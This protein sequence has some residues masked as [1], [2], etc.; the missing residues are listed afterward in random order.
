MCGCVDEDRGERESVCV[1]EGVC[2]RVSMRRAQRRGVSMRRERV[3][4]SMRRGRRESE[5]GHV[6]ER[7][8]GRGC[9][10]E[11]VCVDERVCV[12]MREREGEGGCVDERAGCVDESVRR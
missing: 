6:D 4:V 2:V 10:D 1:D 3:W 9:V 7:E 5:R 8:R 11:C 12:S